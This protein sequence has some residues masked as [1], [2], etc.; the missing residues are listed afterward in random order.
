MAATYIVTLIFGT[1]LY[2]DAVNGGKF[3]DWII[4]P[5]VGICVCHE[6]ALRLLISNARGKN[7]RTIRAL[8]ILIAF[9]FGLC[10]LVGICEPLELLWSAYLWLSRAILGG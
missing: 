2:C 6:L 7:Q 4:T 9:C 1:F 8:H 10:W 3:F 5:F